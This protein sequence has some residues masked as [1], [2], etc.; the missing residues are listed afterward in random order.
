MYNCASGFHNPL[1]WGQIEKIGHDALVKYPM[2]YVMWYPSGSF[3]NNLYHHKLDTIL[4]HYVPAYLLDVLIRL[5]GKRPVLV[6]YSRTNLCLIIHE[7]FLW[8]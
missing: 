8:Q 2:S 4:Y 6:R 5:S 7:L 1:T 3:K